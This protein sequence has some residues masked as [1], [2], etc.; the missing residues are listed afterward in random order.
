MIGFPHGSH[1]TS[2]KAYEAERA[3]ADGATELDMVVNIGKA[4]SGDW[5]YVADDIRA[6]VDLAHAA[7]AKVKVIFI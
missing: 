6:V 7:G 4:L 2:V 5:S 1:L 3:L